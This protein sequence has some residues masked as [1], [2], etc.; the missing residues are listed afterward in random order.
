[1]TFPL[2]V[3]P[4]FCFWSL[5]QTTRSL[6]SPDC[7]TTS[8]WGLRTTSPSSTTTTAAGR[9]SSTTRE[10]RLSS[11]S[12]RTGPRC[13]ADGPKT[14]ASPSD[15][16]QTLDNKDAGSITC[17]IRTSPGLFITPVI[18]TTNWS[19][20]RLWLIWHVKWQPIPSLLFYYCFIIVL[21]LFYYCCVIVGGWM[22]FRTMDTSNLPCD[23]RE[24][25][26][27]SK[28]VA[29]C[30]T[31]TA[32]DALQC[33]LPFIDGGS[34]PV[35]TR[36]ISDFIRSVDLI[37]CRWVVGVLRHSGDVLPGGQDER[38]AALLRVVV[39]QQLL[40]QA[41]VQ[42][43]YLHALHGNDGDGRGIGGTGQ[44]PHLLPSHFSSSTNK[45]YG[46]GGVIPAFLF[47]FF[48]IFAGFNFRWYR[49]SAG[50]LDYSIAV[51]YRRVAGSLSGRVRLDVLR[52]HRSHVDCPAHLHS[53]TGQMYQRLTTVVVV[54]AALLTC[55]P[56][57]FL[58]IFVLFSFSFPILCFFVSSFLCFVES[59]PRVSERQPRH[60]WVGGW[61]INDRENQPTILGN[62][63]PSPMKL[64][65]SSS[66]QHEESLPS[67]VELRLHSTA[68]RHRRPITPALGAASRLDAPGRENITEDLQL[69]C[70]RSITGMLQSD[71]HRQSY[72]GRHFLP[73]RIVLR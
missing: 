25:Y 47:C 39:Q 13:T 60:L 46:T 16:W 27:Y 38:A 41:P 18:R 48:N 36:S 70:W 12:G 72:L 56:R 14:S 64:H 8:T 26:S 10:T 21:L 32:V 68:W 33:R 3:A 62:T 43:E 44:T 7:S 51:R 17:P 61:I 52:D 35:A 31:R 29:R 15:R 30:F 20:N 24:N 66:E 58:S 49:G 53:P 73:K 59:N 11:A 5:V 54:R 69:S 37:S 2:P 9:C 50:L 65:W 42:P 28:C 45:L 1:M 40:L 19:I 55:F 4:W 71:Y 22:Q 63:P 57:L 67:T 23:S 34:W 6:R